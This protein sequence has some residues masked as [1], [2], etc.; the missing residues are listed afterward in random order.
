MNLLLFLL[1]FLCGEPP[2]PSSRLRAIRARSDGRTDAGDEV[3]LAWMFAEGLDWLRFPWK[4]L[5]RGKQRRRARD[6]GSPPRTMAP[7]DDSSA[8]RTL[9]QQP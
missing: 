4:W 9:G 2:R 5:Q 8:D 7:G 6:G 3:S 1:R